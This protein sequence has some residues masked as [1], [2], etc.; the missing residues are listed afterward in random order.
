MKNEYGT[1]TWEVTSPIIG[2][3]IDQ[4]TGC[5]RITYK[6]L[7]HSEYLDTFVVQISPKASLE[8]LSLFHK[9]EKEQV[10]LLEE[11]AKE[12]SVQ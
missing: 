2:F 5:V 6:S 8:L 3:D 7:S 11:K 1:I 12:Y 4:D 10:S 9:L